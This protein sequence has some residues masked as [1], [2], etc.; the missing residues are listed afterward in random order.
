MKYLYQGLHGH[1]NLVPWI[2]SAMAFNITGFL[3]F[4]FPGTRKRFFTLNIGCILIFMGIWIEKE[5]GMVIPGF[6]P[7]SLGEIYE[8]TPSLYEILITVGIYSG[9]A[10]LYTLLARTAIALETG[11]LRHSEAPGVI[12][13]EEENVLARDIMTKN[14]LVA[15][16]DTPIEE[17][18][19]TL[20]ENRISGMPVVDKEYRVIGVISESDII[21]KEIHKEPHLLERLREI[22]LPEE[23]RKERIGEKALDIMTSPAITTF[24]DTP[25]RD[26]IQIFT[27]KKIKRIIIVDSEGRPVGIVS[28]IDIVKA[29]ERI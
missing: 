10:M 24:E 7:D 6:V 15:D 16:H 11:R 12:L 26:M 20:I 29:I 9:G 21:F 4:L 3:I 8:Y 22:I 5:M 19:R 18:T 17:I 27:E 2:W 14:V 28:R 13:S 23:R 1:N 25:L